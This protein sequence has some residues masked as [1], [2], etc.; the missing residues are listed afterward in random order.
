[1]HNNSSQHGN[2]SHYRVN[3]RAKTIGY[4]CF[5]IVR[6]SPDAIVRWDYRPNPNSMACPANK[7]QISSLDQELY[8]SSV[9]IPSRATRLLFCYKFIW[10]R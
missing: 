3:Y 9:C 4:D 10:V 7:S 1:M 6:L 2:T 5:P 8:M